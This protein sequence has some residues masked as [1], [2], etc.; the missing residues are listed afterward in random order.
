MVV[1]RR[2][3]G[4]KAYV[5]TEPGESPS[6]YSYHPISCQSSRCRGGGY[7]RYTGMSEDISGHMIE[8][9]LQELE[10]NISTSILKCAAP[11]PPAP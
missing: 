11:Q 7:A 8:S 5:P 6:L 9:P 3:R 4:G 1:S 10:R 2:G